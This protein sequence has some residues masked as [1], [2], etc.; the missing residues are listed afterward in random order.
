MNSYISTILSDASLSEEYYQR[1]YDGNMLNM[2]MS[3][4]P[5]DGLAPNLDSMYKDIHA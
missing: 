1:N 4:E 2:V 5:S 3:A